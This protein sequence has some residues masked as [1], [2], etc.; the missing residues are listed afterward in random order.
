MIVPH[1]AGAKDR[2]RDQGA[3][4]GLLSLGTLSDEESKKRLGEVRGS[5]MLTKSSVSNRSQ[6]RFNSEGED[7]YMFRNLQFS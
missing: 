4:L 7:Q 6:P 2:R 3:A 5:N 1:G